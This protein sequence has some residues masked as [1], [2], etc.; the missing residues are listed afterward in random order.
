MKAVFLDRNTFSPALDFPAPE[1]VRTWV[2]HDRTAAH[3][4][5]ARAQGADIVLTNKVV[6]D[7]A[8]IDALPDLKLVQ[9]CATGINNVDVAACEARGIVVQNVAGYSTQSVPEHAWMGIL[10]A[11]R[12]LGHYHGA[13]T[14]GTW[15]RDGRFTLNDLPVLDVAGRVLTII[16]AGNI[17]RR[18]GSIARAFDMEVLWAEQRGKAARSAD[19]TPF[20]EA[21]ARAD[22]V[23][24]HCPLTEH[25]RHLINHETIALMHKRPLLVNM[26]RGGVVDST[27]VAQAV[28]EGRL[29]GYV[30]DV[31]ADE[32]LTA[33]DPLWDIRHHPRVVYTPHN[34]WAS[35]GAQRKLWDILSARV[36]D[37][38]QERKGV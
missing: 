2:V 18:V 10:A 4:V 29:L 30:S 5:V 37:F 11:M 32:P 20:A 16:G 36:A 17:G 7:K 31:F 27:A 24:L 8:I 34:A 28:Q 1:G 12:G 23:S 3:E 6:L 9:V 19:Y 14:D 15:Q 33:S 26:A 25:T 22:I 38:I 35:D 13:A 21:L